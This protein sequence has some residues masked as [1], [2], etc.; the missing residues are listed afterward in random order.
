MREKPGQHHRVQES[1]STPVGPLA[2]QHGL[3][4]TG[5]DADLV[6]NGLEGVDGNSG[7]GRL[8]RVDP[9]GDG[10]ELGAFLSAG[11]AEVGTPDSSRSCSRLFRATPRPMDTG[12]LAVRYK[13]NPKA[14]GTS[15]STGRHHRRY[16]NRRNAPVDSIRHN[17]LGS[18]HSVV[19]VEQGGGDTSGPDRTAMPPS[20]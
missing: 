5:T 6:D 7:V 13:A 2:Q 9:D 1:G 17:R 20:G 4:G 3:G 14:A 15:E 10:H 12:R 18:T 19:R 11:E 8:V 16:D